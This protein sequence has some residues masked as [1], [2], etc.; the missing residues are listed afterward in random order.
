MI[1]EIELICSE[2]RGNFS[3]DSKLFYKENF[4]TR[5]FA[6]I[7]LICQQC[8]DKWLEYWKIKEAD[9]FEEGASF[10]VDIT[11]ANGT[12]LQKIDCT[13]MDDIVALDRDI[14]LEAQ[15][16]LYHIYK[17]WYDKKMRDAIK[18]CQFEEVFMRTSFTCETYGGEKYTD[19][20][21]RF[22]RT[23]I[24]ETEKPIPDA[25]GEQ[26]IK[27]WNKYELANT[28]VRVNEE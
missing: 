28:M 2:C 23:G 20:A 7:E 13:A 14:P 26:V 4:K 5:D 11:L 6:E 3:A 9:F 25:I 18:H 8:L 17:K 19:I 27:L 16:E 1:R 12:V 10:Y 15:K 24:L 22:T 21:F